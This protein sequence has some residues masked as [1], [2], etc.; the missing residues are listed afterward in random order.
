MF[1]HILT[2]L[3]LASVSVFATADSDATRAHYEVT[4]TNI[5]PGQSFTPQLVVTHPA[6]WHLFELGSPAGTALEKLAEGGDTGPLT[7]MVADIAFEAKTVGGLIGPG[8][9][10]TTTISGPHRGG[11]L[12]IAA[13]LI[14]TNDTFMALD[15][16]KLPMFGRKTQFIMAYDAGTEDN[17]QSCQHIPGP[18]CGGSGYSPEP[19]PGDEGFVH[20]GNGF[21]ALGD[22]DGDGFEVLG[23]KLYDWGN[24]VARVSVR[25]VR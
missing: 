5:T 23:P 1:K 17:D 12:S 13:M 2:G 4:I 19:S 7:E 25:R 6:A 16:L 8:E 14:P 22:V 9:T 3:L 21:H 24:P 20:I 18:R 11:R 10:A 15:S